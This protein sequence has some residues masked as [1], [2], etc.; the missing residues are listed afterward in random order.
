MGE[1][2][3]TLG[4]EATNPEHVARGTLSAGWLPC[5]KSPFV[6]TEERI[7]NLQIVQMKSAAPSVPCPGRCWN[8]LHFR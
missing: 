6:L 3:E 7:S 8:Q 4:A 2:H 1:S 5:D